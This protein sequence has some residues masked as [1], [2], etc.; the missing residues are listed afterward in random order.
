MVIIIQQDATEY[1]LFKSVNCSTCFGWYFTHHQE[2]I[3]LYLQYLALITPVL[4]PVVNVAGRHAQSRSRQVA[5][6]STGLIY[7]RYFRYSGMSS[8]CW[9]K[10]HPKYVEQLTDL[11]KMYSVA[12]CWIIIAILY[13]ARSIEHKIKFPSCLLL[14]SFLN[15]CAH[16]PVWFS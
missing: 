11:N 9:V 8:W 16:E 14:I 12:S 13:D 7:A 6:S 4:L 1:S 3:S 5:D 2:L 15:S 10:Y